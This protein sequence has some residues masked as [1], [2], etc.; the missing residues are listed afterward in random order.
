MADSI[1]PPAKDVLGALG[2]LNK[3]GNKG[4]QI[5]FKFYQKDFAVISNILVGHFPLYLVLRSQ[6]Y[7]AERNQHFKRVQR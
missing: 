3:L 1:A 2:T 7:L 6:I 4:T 5:F